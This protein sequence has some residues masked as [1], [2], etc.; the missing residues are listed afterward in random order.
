MKEH[1]RINYLERLGIDVWCARD[2]DKNELSE[3]DMNGIHAKASDRV[4][5]EECNTYHLLEGALEKN[6]Y[7]G[8][9]FLAENSNN[10]TSYSQFLWAKTSRLVEAML[11]SINL[12]L[13]NIAISV[14]CCRKFNIKKINYLRPKK[15]VIF[16]EKSAQMMLESQKPINELR[17]IIHRIENIPSI[18]SF[19]PNELFK[20]PDLKKEASRDLTFMESII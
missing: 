15:I 16:G 17:Q 8:L 2:T 10:D 18:V 6:H 7:S 1:Q 19:H 3:Y 11:Y 13:K 20:N 9:L 14:T 12:E 5:C 4:L